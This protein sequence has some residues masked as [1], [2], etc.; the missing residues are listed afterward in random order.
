[1]LDEVHD[2]LGLVVVVQLIQRVLVLLRELQVGIVR[3]R[4][5]FVGRQSEESEGDELR[6]ELVEPLVSERQNLLRR[7]KRKKSIRFGRQES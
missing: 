4:L 1:M 5:E 2:D 3:G 6:T 7:S